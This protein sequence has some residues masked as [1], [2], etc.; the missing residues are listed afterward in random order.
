MQAPSRDADTIRSVTRVSL[1]T[2]RQRGQ[3]IAASVQPPAVQAAASCVREC[4]S[5]LV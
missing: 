3:Q 2:L 1:L 5:S 4:T